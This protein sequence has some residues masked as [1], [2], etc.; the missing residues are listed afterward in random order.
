MSSSICE[1]NDIRTPSQ[2]RTYSFS[3]FKKTV[4]CHEL[5]DNMQKQKIE[6]ACYWAAEL[7]CAGH[8]YDLW[9]LFIQ[10][11]GQHIHLGNPKILKYM[12]MRY[13]I[14]SN[15]VKQ[16]HYSSELNLRNHPQI[17]KLFAEIIVV[18]SYSNRKHSLILMQIDKEEEFI[19][20]K[21]IEKST[22]ST[23]EYVDHLFRKEDPMELYIPINEFVYNV[24]PAVKNMRNACYWIEWLIDFDA[25]NRKRKTP[26]VCERRKEAKMVEFKLQNDVIWILWEAL[27]QQ[28]QSRG[29]YIE[30]LM[31][32]LL[33]LF[34]IKYT[35]ACSKKRRFLLYFG[36]S[37]LTEPVLTNVEI[38]TK[39]SVIETVLNNIDEI[40]KQIKPN[41]ISPQTDY[42]YN[43]LDKEMN[44]EISLRKI[45]MM[46][47]MGLYG[48]H[49]K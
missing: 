4:V 3:N 24:S 7:I 17:R 1:I 25:L 47:S 32:S 35:S 12:E 31:K 11:I 41:E 40:Y 33:F 44:F 27:I 10:Y 21:L 19:V 5:I 6:P 9:E 43:N 49:G 37:L 8:F 29:N 34:S 30:E 22:A 46:N 15:I 20:E 13:Q 26:L 42:L 38:T 28:S 48:D 14:F 36:V 18:L 45:E 2:F 39:K 16:G 23:T